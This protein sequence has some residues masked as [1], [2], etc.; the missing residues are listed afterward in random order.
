M[1]TPPIYPARP[2]GSWVWLLV[3]SPALLGLTIGLT[4]ADEEGFV[5]A[6]R[7]RMEG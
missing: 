2:P 6:L 3:I 7:A 4:P 5:A 1:K